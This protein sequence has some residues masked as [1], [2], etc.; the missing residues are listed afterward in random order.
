MNNNEPN[1]KEFQ[2][3]IGRFV[4]YLNR[5]IRKFQY[6]SGASAE[7]DAIAFLA[8]F[9]EVELKA[10]SRAV[11]PPS[12]RDVYEGDLKTAERFIWTGLN[13]NEPEAGIARLVC[14][15]AAARAPLE[16]KAKALEEE[17]KQDLK[18]LTAKGNGKYEG[19]DA[20]EYDEWLRDRTERLAALVNPPK[21]EE[22]ESDG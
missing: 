13:T 10:E 5:N 18:F 15:L 8:Y 20:L 17:L 19:S 21:A 11:T 6:E 16:A 3:R 2:E 14:L 22:V 4:N 7:V 9:S 12:D 1:E